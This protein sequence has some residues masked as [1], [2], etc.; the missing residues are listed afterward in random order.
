MNRSFVSSAVHIITDAGLDVG[1]LD[2]DYRDNE[3]YLLMIE[4]LPAAG[5]SRAR[6][7]S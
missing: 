4:L 2:L 5:L 7:H 3:I 1:W 6:R